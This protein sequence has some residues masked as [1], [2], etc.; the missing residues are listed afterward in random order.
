MTTTKKNKSHEYVDTS[1]DSK[2]FRKTALIIGAGPAG[3]TAAYELIT[4][5]GIKPI[6]LEATD[7]LG[8]ISTTKV[9]KGNRIDIGGHRFFSKSQRVMNFWMNFLPLESP[10]VV[11]P[12]KTDLVFLIRNRL[13]RILYQGKFFFYPIT[14]SLQT[15][16]NMGI[17]KTLKVGFSYIYVKLKPIKPENNLEDFFINRFGQELYQSFFKYYNYKVWGKYPSQMSADWG[18]QRIKGVSIHKVL[19]TAFLDLLGK[20]FPIQQKERETSLIQSFYYPKLGPGQMWETVAHE[21]ISKG[22]IVIKNNNV[23]GI[24]WEDNVI[25][26]VE[27][28]NTTTGE[29]STFTADYYFSTMPVV[30]LINS[31]SPKV[32]DNVSKVANGLEYRD[33]ITVGVLLSKFKN[34]EQMKDNWIYIHDGNVNVGRIQIFN[35]WSPYMIADQSKKWLGLEYFCQEN[36]SFWN[37]SDQELSDMAKHELQKIGLGNISDVLDTVVIRMKKTYP[38]YTGTYDQLNV[39]KEFVS[40]FTNL[41]LVGRNGLHRYNNQDHSMLTAMFSVDN[42]ISGELSKENIW[43]VNTE[44]YY[45]EEKTS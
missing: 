6:V 26:S 35:N 30:D 7:S 24:N 45:H 20:V 2:N 23:V 10:P 18:A 21:V 11:D 29:K 31:M 4:R 9:Y 17:V 38:S 16:R 3:L 34:N 33:F 28:I 36:D 13:S 22:G 42:I 32:P 41:Y 15:L 27:A 25:K 19:T 43:N 14:L 8:G 44:D 1:D 5:A 40:N 37:K 12:E 39:I